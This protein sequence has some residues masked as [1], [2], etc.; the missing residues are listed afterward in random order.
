MAQAAEHLERALKLTPE[1][2]SKQSDLSRAAA[3]AA[4]QALCREGRA[5]FDIAGGAYRWRQLLPFAVP[6]G[7]EDRNWRRRSAFIE[8][9]G[10]KCKELRP[11]M[12]P[13]L[14][15][16]ADRRRALV[17]G[18][19]ENQR[20][21]VPR[22]GR[23]GRRRHARFSRSARAASF[24]AIN[25][26]RGRVRTLLAATTIA[27]KMLS[28]ATQNV[29][30]F[31]G[32]TW[33]FAGALSLFTR[34]Q[35]QEVIEQRRWQSGGQRLEKHD[36]FGGGR[37]RRIEAA[38]G[39]IAGRAGAQRRAISNDSRRARRAGRG[40]G[41]QRRGAVMSEEQVNAAPEE[42]NGRQLAPAHPLDGQ[43]GVSQAE[44]LRLGFWPNEPG[45]AAKSGRDA[46]R[47]RFAARANGAAGRRNAATA[48]RESL[49]P[50]T[51]RRCSTRFAASASSACAPSERYA[52]SRASA[53]REDKAAQYATWRGQTLPHLGREVSKGL[54][55]EGGDDE[56]L[57][58]PRP[59]NAPH[60]GGSRGGHRDRAAPTGVADLS[61][62][63]QF[64]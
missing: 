46:G 9:G 6:P 19:R 59:A 20:R 27:G 61:S 42:E 2:R 44:M 13:M 10:V 50:A 49:A 38:K 39:A 54:R 57:R 31:K 1:E 62:R 58:A 35:A 51:C 26:A 12:L 45:G 36:L 8:A 63:R 14:Q 48:R 4:L 23:F 32:Q 56:K 29:E 33:V 22:H 52:R 16:Y 53:K 30:R 43:T 41:N 37:A 40:E 55:Y 24:A 47:T 17:R 15:R 5:M 28:S 3:T 60:G 18:E 25:C 7:E 64:H 34:E 21:H 11:P